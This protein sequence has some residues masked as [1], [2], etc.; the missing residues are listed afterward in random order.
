MTT[1]A[2]WAGIA[3][4]VVTA[5]AGDVLQ[6]RAMKEIGDLGAIQQGHGV[7]YLVRRVA[8]SSRFMLGLLFMALAFFSL[9]VT[10]SWDDVSVVG[11]ASASLTFIANAFAAR[12]FLKERVD[13]RRWL[14]ALFVAGGV[15]LLAR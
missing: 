9:L 14:A 10:L 5:T 12:I 4:I 15:A 8:S 3:S 11:P 7:F 6:S 2:T 1:A 13:H